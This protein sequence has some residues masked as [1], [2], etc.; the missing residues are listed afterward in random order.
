MIS[1]THSSREFDISK[2]DPYD[3]VKCRL[4]E[5][6]DELVKPQIKASR[7]ALLPGGM[8]LTG[9]VSKTEGIDEFMLDVMDL[10]ARIAMPVDAN[11][12]PPGRNTQEYSSAAGIIKYILTRERDPFRYLD[13]PAIGG[14]KAEAPKMQVYAPPVGE[15][16]QAGQKEKKEGGF[17]PLKSI[18][19]MFKDLF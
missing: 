5:L 1:S 15:G 4:E 10:P 2:A 12:M 13:N 3:I 14:G 9:G 8:L 7:V 17:N 16:S 19:D 18:G 11:R 6:A